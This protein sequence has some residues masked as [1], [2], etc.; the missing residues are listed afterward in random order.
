MSGSPRAQ[1]PHYQILILEEFERIG[2]QVIFLDQLLSDDPPAHL[3]TQIRGAVVEYERI[4]LTEW[5]R[6]GKLFRARQGEVYWW[7]VPYGYW[8]IPRCDG[9]PAYVEVS[10]PKA[11]VVR[12]ILLRLTESR[13]VEWLR[14]G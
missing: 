2:V 12:Q 5:N 3:L 4:K 13:Q 7:K 8:R 14:F 10:E 9:V 6:R 1:V 11:Q